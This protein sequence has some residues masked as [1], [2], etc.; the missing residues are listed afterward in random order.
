MK[1]NVLLQTLLALC[2]LFAPATAEEVRLFL[3]HTNDLHGHLEADV[4]SGGFVRLATLIRSIKATFPDEVILFDGGDMAVGTPISG[5]YFGKPMAEA[6][7]SLDY[8]AVAIGNHEFDWGQQAMA[9]FLG[10]VGA[11]A[12]C[13]NLVETGDGAHPYRPWAIVEKQGVRLGV[14]GLVA[15][16]TASRAPRSATEGWQFLPPEVA[17]RRALS[18]MP[19]VDVVVAL[20]HL[21]VQADQQLA[22]AVPEIDLIVGGHSHTALQEAIY[23]NNTPIV[24]SGSYAQY[25]GSIELCVDTET[26]SLKILSYR[27]IPISD[28]IGNDPQVSAIVERYAAKLRSTLDRI[29]A[30]VNGV[31]RMT[32][33]QDTIDSPLGN[34]VADAFRSQTGADVA[35]YNRGG[36]RN[37]MAAGPL[38]VRDIHKLF[39]YDDP[40]VVLKMSGA[41]LQT[42][43]EQGSKM[44]AKL[45]P[46]GLTAILDRSGKAAVLVADSPL[47]PQQDYTVA[48]TEFLATGGDGMSILAGQTISRKFPFTRDLF[49]EFLT[50]QPILD[51][52]QSGRV[53]IQK[54]SVR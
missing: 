34:L 40:V 33:G 39:P 47:D 14:I 42:V 25:L 18:E 54:T 6:M 41:E 53:K 9:E 48:T 36:V 2:F 13:A 27:L 20:T 32:P 50:S 37:D 46:S 24:Q 51:P 49:L 31:V 4:E 23:K 17:V 5:L 12:L 44:R 43:I 7:R 26:D 8:D 10:E 29:A 16:D 45:S 15:P 38:S 22:E 11:P 21:G 19:E 30:Q 28:S 52:P 3:L 1:S 35:L